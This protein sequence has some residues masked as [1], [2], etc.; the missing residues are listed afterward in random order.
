MHASLTTPE[1]VARQPEHADEN[2]RQLPS[3]RSVVVRV[4]D[5][6][7]ELEVRSPGGEVEIRI[8]LTETGPVVSLRGARLELES[9]ETVAVKCRSFEVNAS[10]GVAIAG[11]EM[12][13][14][15]EDDIHL[16]GKI[17]RLNC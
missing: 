13:V 2:A 7:E 16:N 14:K 12:R 8:V 9:A 6:K 17:I 3:G 15:T 4:H 11:H 5:S 10:E 1:T